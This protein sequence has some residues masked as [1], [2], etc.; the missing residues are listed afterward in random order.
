MSLEY[1]SLQS[2]DDVYAL[3]ELMLQAVAEQ[4]F[5]PRVKPERVESLVWRLFHREPLLHHIV[6]KKDGVMIA[7]AI[8]AVQEDLL[9]G[10]RLHRE[11]SAYV[12]PSERGVLGGKI[13]Q[14]FQ[15]SF[16]NGASKAVC[17][18]SDNYISILEGMGFVKYGN[19]MLLDKGGENG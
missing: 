5:A 18:I 9:T 7:Y 19:A 1:A 13:V 15:K 4:S 16:L 2:I 11:I 3:K 14:F 10:E 6:V 12:K 17:T 8:W